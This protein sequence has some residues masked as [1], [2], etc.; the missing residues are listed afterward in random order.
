MRSS[1]IS[2]EPTVEPVTVAEAKLY[3]GVDFDEWN[4]RISSLITGAR[5]FV[6][7]YTHRALITQTWES[8]FDD[9]APRLFLPFPPLQSVT[10]VNY[11]DT[12]GVEQTV[13]SAVYNVDTYSQPGAVSLVYGQTWPTPRLEP[14]AVRITFVAG[15]GDAGSDVAEELRTAIL[16]LVNTWMSV[17]EFTAVG[18]I[19][20][21]TSAPSHIESLLGPYRLALP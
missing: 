17:R 4:D 20:S 11:I 5:R 7:G 16:M 10:T 21:Q 8:R 12:A 1:K 13:N 18:R 15:F 2:V 9:F 3:M 19:V 14:H 6:E